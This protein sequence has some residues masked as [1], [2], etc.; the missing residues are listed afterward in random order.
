MDHISLC[1]EHY[2]TRNR[3]SP[4]I[5]LINYLKASHPNE[6]R[7]LAAT[8]AQSAEFETEYDVDV[9]DYHPVQPL[10]HDHGVSFVCLSSPHSKVDQHVMQVTK[11]VLH[12]RRSLCM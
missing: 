1:H 7:V 3:L 9:D 5:S 8:P 10:V 4:T 11:P 6:S 2:H 12:F